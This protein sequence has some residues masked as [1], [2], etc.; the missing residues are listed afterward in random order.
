MLPCIC[1]VICHRGSYK[2]TKVHTRLFHA[3]LFQFCCGLQESTF[4][5][6]HEYKNIVCTTKTKRKT[7]PLEEI[8]LTLLEE[9]H[10]LHFNH[11]LSLQNLRKQRENCSSIVMNHHFGSRICTAS[12][13]AKTHP[14]TAT[15]T[16]YDLL[17]CLYWKTGCE[18]NFKSKLL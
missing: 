1:S 10:P 16:E 13:S 6:V 8:S 9:K 15:T 18:N 4:P 3:Q 17:Q 14:R 11:L 2:R 5:V 7:H 12:A